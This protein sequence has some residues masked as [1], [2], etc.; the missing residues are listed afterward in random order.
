MKK[1]TQVEIMFWLKTK[2]KINVK[3]IHRS[4]KEE[5]FKNLC[6]LL[7]KLRQINT[8]FSPNEI[9][10]EYIEE[11]GIE[12]LPQSFRGTK[13]DYEF[14]NLTH[15]NEEDSIEISLYHLLLSSWCRPTRA[16]YRTLKKHLKSLGYNIVETIT[17]HSKTMEKEAVVRIKRKY[18]LQLP[19]NLKLFKKKISWH[20]NITQYA[21]YEMQPEVLLDNEKYEIR[22]IGARWE[23]YFTRRFNDLFNMSEI[24]YLHKHPKVKNAYENAPPVLILCDLAIRDIFKRTEL[25]EWVHTALMHRLDLITYHEQHESD[26][27]KEFL[28][29]IFD[30]IVG[31]MSKVMIKNTT[32]K[33]KMF[34]EGWISIIILCLINDTIKK[35][36]G[37][38]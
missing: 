38:I 26:K 10:S 29:I 30:E 36:E 28:N 35:Y 32:L 31:E 8:I 9:I 20:K 19:K 11:H 14:F 34:V 27:G 2:Y 33:D 25:K 18:D 4:L 5:D 23:A 24:P 17:P 13:I 3:Y 12:Y 7:S 37:I 22:D 1:I 16:N 21:L 15:P 6:V